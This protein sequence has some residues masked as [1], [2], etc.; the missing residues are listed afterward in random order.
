LSFCFRIETGARPIG[1]VFGGFA[2]LHRRLVVVLNGLYLTRRAAPLRATVLSAIES[3]LCRPLG[4]AVLGIANT[5]GAY[6]PLP[7]TYVRRPAQLVRLRALRDVGG[8]YDDISR[9][10]NAP[11]AVSN[12]HWRQL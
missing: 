8:G 7:P 1:F 12:L 11:I 2:R 6:G 5:N 10:F 4:I 3:M 9:R